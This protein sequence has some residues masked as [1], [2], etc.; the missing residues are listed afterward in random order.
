ML[1][2]AFVWMSICLD[3]QRGIERDPSQVGVTVPRGLWWNSGLGSSCPNSA[4]SQSL[5]QRAGDLQSLFVCPFL[6]PDGFELVHDHQEEMGSCFM[7]T[8]PSTQGPSKQV[9]KQMMMM[10]DK[11]GEVAGLS[12]I[13]GRFKEG[14]IFM[15][16]LCIFL[17]FFVK[18]VS[19]VLVSSSV[20]VGVT[21]W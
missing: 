8:S 17:S 21:L 15:L 12:R 5:W 2:Y 6:L 13:I 16:C 20:Q 3:A 19:F 9:I 11:K 1:E 14:L 18:Q 10:K 4:V 7:C